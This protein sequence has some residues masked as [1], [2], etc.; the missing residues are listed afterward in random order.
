MFVVLIKNLENTSVRFVADIL[1]YEALNPITVI[2]K[3]T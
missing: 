3:W 2:K 1:A